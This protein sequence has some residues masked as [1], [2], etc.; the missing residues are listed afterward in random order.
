MTEVRLREW[1]ADDAD[2][3]A[4]IVGDPHLLRWSSMSDDVA[5]WI[6]R[7]RAGVRGPSLA[8]CLTDD[9][10]ALGKVALRMP[11]HASPA[12]SCEAI[13][14]D[15]QPAGELSYWLLPDARGKGLGRLAVQEMVRTVVA[16]SG[17]RSVVLDI[18]ENNRASMALAA[19]LG[20]ERRE[21]IR[22][23]RDRTG[24]P[25]RLVVFV[26]RVRST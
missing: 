16:G 23:Q 7:Q 15:D 22:V 3:I 8:I 17:L 10:R 20:A 18:E 25:Q 11:G 5:G 4:A 12:T 14:P 13:R 24:E 6:E 21:P 19:R 1:R 26:L 2:A 9:D